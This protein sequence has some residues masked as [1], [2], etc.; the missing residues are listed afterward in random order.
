MGLPKGTTNNPA[1]RPKGRAN[2]STDRLRNLLFDLINN[3]LDNLQTDIS[4][5]EP[6]QR[7]QMIDRLLKHILPP[8]M[9][10]LERLDNDSLDMLIQKLR[11]DRNNIN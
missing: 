1:G 3:N 2:R 10:P 7:L 4:S 8:P 9:D 11:E 5:L 6:Y